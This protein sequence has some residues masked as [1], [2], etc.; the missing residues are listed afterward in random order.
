MVVLILTATPVGLRGEV[1]RWLE[2]VAPGVFVGNL[3][4]RV[5]ERLWEKV[6]ARLGGGRAL[7]V[8]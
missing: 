3:G 5:R 7:M 4:K 2:E 1:S 8:Y 6:V